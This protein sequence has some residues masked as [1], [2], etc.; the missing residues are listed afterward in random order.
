MGSILGAVV[1]FKF[2]IRGSS[3]AVCSSVM[4]RA[5]LSRS[6][7]EFSLKF[8]RE[9]CNP[10]YLKKMK[11]QM[12][13]FALCSPPKKATA[14]LHYINNFPKSG[15]EGKKRR[16]EEGNSTVSHMSQRQRLLH[17]RLMA[18]RH[19][20]PWCLAQFGHLCGEEKETSQSGSPARAPSPVW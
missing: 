2:K 15:K 13:L 5:I 14:N 6:V 1:F 20:Q 12:L 18:K 16:K 4:L 10:C 7:G 8:S 11:I 3:N 17:N 9:I 19:Q